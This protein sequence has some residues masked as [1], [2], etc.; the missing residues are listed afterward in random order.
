VSA[1][2]QA[3]QQ[4]QHESKRGVGEALKGAW[5]QALASVNAAEEE[6][7]KLLGRVGEWV[8][9]GPDEAKKV[10][11]ELAE[12]LQR[13]R[14]ELEKSLESAVAKALQRFRLPSKDE[15]AA[16]ADRVEKIALRLE[17]IERARGE[18][19]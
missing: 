11:R 18:Q 8:E 16:L 3:Q 6:T 2:Q 5:A 4:Q 9:V 15:V 14:A 12:R 10:A 17:E 1:D 7:K 13:Q 19:Q